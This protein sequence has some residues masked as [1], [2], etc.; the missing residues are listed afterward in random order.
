MV[1]VKVVTLVSRCILK[2]YPMGFEGG[3]E[4]GVIK[5]ESRKT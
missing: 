5:T 1:V 2:D 3:L 4:V